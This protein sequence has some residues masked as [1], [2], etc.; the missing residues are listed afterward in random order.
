M[1]ESNWRGI[2]IN[3][4]T[5]SAFRRTAAGYPP[6]AL[7][8]SVLHELAAGDFAH[9]EMWSWEEA[10]RKFPECSAAW[11][12]DGGPERVA[13]RPGLA[14]VLGKHLAVGWGDVAPFGWALWD[15]MRKSWLFVE[16]HE[17]Q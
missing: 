1:S 4:D 17:A 12:R 15:A 3:A 14:I 8:S 2:T 5:R 10:E 11:D 16:A 7:D 6:C 13:G 9:A